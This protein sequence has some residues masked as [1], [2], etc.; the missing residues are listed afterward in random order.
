MS[1]GACAGLRR[2]VCLRSFNFPAASTVAAGVSASYCVLLF[3]THVE[4][5]DCALEERQLIRNSIDIAVI[6]QAPRTYGREVNQN[7]A[8]GDSSVA[9]DFLLLIG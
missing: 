7:R 9:A 3:S 1:S 6:H 4:W 8:T 5:Q 2:R